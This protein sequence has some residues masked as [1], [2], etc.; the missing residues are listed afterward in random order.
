MISRR[1]FLRGDI[2]GRKTFQRPPW[3]QPE[4]NFLASCTRCGDCIGACPE[5]IIVVERGLP[6]LD[7]LLGACTFCGACAAACK[8]GALKAVAGERPWHIRPT[9]GPACMALQNVVCRTCGDA[10]EAVAIRFRPRL[11]GAALPEV[12]GGKCTG[13][14][15][16]VAPCP[17]KA[18][19]L[20]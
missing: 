17:S 2:S 11:G 4:A 14:G 10:C 6:V 5:K 19:T 7:F 20:A 18:I 13:C 12:D 15:A 3:A 16:C 8:P 1:Q 9:F